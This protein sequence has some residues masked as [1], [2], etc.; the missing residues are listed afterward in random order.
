MQGNFCFYRKG[1]GKFLSAK[2][3]VAAEMSEMPLKKSGIERKCTDT[4]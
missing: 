1:T 2:Y 4:I 3:D